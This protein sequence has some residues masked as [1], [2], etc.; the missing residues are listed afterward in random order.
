MVRWLVDRHIAGRTKHL[1]LSEEELI[2]ET[3]KSPGVLMASGYIAG[4]AIAGIG[5]A[6]LS[7]GMEKFDQRISDV[8]TAS[9]PFFNGPWSDALALIPFAA[10]MLAL[11]LA[12]RM[13]TN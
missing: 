2:A 12:G 3:D 11:Y 1:N 8:M 10:I 4:G 13:R 9:N 6:F 7:G 5:I